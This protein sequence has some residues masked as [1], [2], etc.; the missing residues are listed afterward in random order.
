MDA[1]EE[2]RLWEDAYAEKPAS[3]DLTLAFFQEEWARV[4]QPQSVGSVEEYKKPHG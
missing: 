4:I 1:S 2:K 3:A